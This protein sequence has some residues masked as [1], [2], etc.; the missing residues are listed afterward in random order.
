MK[1]KSMAFLLALVLSFTFLTACGKKDTDEKTIRVGA[2]V[3]PH[4]EILKV[5]GEIL[6]GQGYT[7]EIVEFT[8]YVQPNLNVESGD[9]EANYFQH[10]QYLDQFNVENNTHLVSVADVHYEP[11]GVY[12]GKTASLEELPDG[13]AVA[14]PNDTTNEARALLL[15]QDLGLIELKEGVGLEATQI[16]IVS[17]PR[18]LEFVEME[19]AQLPKVLSDVDIAVINGNYAIQDGLSVGQDA[20]AVEDKDSEIIRSDYVNVLAVKE[21][22]ENNE[23]IQALVKALQSSEVRDYINETYDG[24]V[25]PIF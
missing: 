1:K 18:N 7:L 25:V 11:F 16:D 20:I 21:G 8:D 13:A 19:A 9:L 10:Q 3:T 15:L 12:P 4:A 22:S 14:V 2:S 24:A 5:A 6:A 17:N 23:A